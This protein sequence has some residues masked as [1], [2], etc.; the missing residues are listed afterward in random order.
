MKQIKRMLLMLLTALLMLSM[1]AAY[2]QE[3]Y[4]DVGISSDSKEH[5]LLIEYEGDVY[6]LLNDSHLNHSILCRI[7]DG[8]STQVYSDAGIEDIYSHESG[9]V[10]VREKKTLGSYFVKEKDLESC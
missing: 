5:N 9:I 7:A 4:T 10:L 8:K 6:C 3:E 1:T 2:A